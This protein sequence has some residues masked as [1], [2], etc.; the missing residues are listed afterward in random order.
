MTKLKFIPGK[1]YSV[2]ELLKLLRLNELDLLNFINKHNI[3]FQFQDD[4]MVILGQNIYNA[5]QNLS[6]IP[7]DS[8]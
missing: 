3:S 6:C 8:P 5:I 4:R 7:P 2:A 1:L